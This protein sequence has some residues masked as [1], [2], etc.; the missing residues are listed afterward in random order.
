MVADHAAAEAVPRPSIEG[1][2]AFFG[3]YRNGE[4]CYIVFTGSIGAA[5][6]QPEAAQTLL[7]LLTSPAAIAFAKSQGFEPSPR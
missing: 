6:K 1:G 3:R 7:S 2:G 4:Q 5:A